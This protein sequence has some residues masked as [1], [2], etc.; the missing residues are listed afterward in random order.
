MDSFSKYPILYIIKAKFEKIVII[1]YEL[2]YLLA[3]FQAMLLNFKAISIPYENNRGVK[4]I[5]HDFFI[6]KYQLHPR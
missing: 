1:F 5:L 3:T 2:Y 6:I 4:M